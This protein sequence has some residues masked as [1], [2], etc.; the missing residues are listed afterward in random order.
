MA[1]RAWSV[2]LIYGDWGDE[3]GDGSITEDINVSVPKVN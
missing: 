1:N 3:S 2:D